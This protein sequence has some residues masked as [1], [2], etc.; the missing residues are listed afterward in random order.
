MGLLTNFPNLGHFGLN[1]CSTNNSILY[2]GYSFYDKVFRY[3][4]ANIIDEQG[5]ISSLNVADFFKKIRFVAR[6]NPWL[7]RVFTAYLRSNSR[8]T[9]HSHTPIISTLKPRSEINA[10]N[11][12]LDGT[13]TGYC[14]HPP[15]YR[16]C[17]S[18]SLIK[19]HLRKSE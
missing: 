7:L 17:K 2:F 12:F 15:L 14:T 5:Y 16:L 3:S 10:P 6:Q 9:P 18:N 4:V 19:I 1:N 13:S 11:P 8:A